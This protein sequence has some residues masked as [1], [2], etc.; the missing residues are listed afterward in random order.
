M[1]V[2][3]ILAE[4]PRL[5]EEERRVIER[6]LYEVSVE[7]TRKWLERWES[8]PPL[9][10]GHWA[11]VFEEWT[12]KGEEDVPEDFSVNHDHYIHGAPKKW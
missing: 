9:P 8:L 7:E 6:A 4:L 10:P 12:G 3:R 2:E 1:S 5:T 11:E